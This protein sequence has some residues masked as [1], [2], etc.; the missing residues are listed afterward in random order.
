[1][2]H[3]VYLDAFTLRLATSW[4]LQRHHRWPDSSNPHLFVNRNTAVDDSI[5]PI[6][7]PPSN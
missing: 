7:P 6:A 4:E 3:I 2:D 1:M 5:P